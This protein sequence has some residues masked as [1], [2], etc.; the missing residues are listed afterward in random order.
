MGPSDDI[1]R[2]LCALAV[3]LARMID[4]DR[5][6][7]AGLADLQAHIAAGDLLQW[8]GELD[9]RFDAWS[10]GAEG[11]FAFAAGEWLQ[12]LRRQL[13]VFDLK[14][15]FGVYHSGLCALLALTVDQLKF[16]VGRLLDEP[17]AAAAG[18]ARH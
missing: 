16:E 15:D 3:N 11:P 2:G 12:G 10:F 17:R 1:Y 9:P 14:D 8:L 4:H 18:F 7:S 6:S 13:A 5:H